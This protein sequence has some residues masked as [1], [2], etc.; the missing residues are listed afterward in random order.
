MLN[1]T[2]SHGLGERIPPNQEVMLIVQPGSKSYGWD[3][4]RLPWIM[5]DPNE[6]FPEMAVPLNF[7]NHPFFWAGFSMA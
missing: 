3:S 2:K 4:D 1:P 6:G 5:F 7:L